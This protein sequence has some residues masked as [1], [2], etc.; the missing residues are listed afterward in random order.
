MRVHASGF[1]CYFT[2]VIPVPQAFRLSEDMKKALISL[3][4]EMK[5]AGIRG[6]YTPREN[7]HLMLAFIGEYNDPKKV[8]DVLDGL[9]FRPIPLSLDGVGSFGEVWWAGLKTSD[10]LSSLAARLRKALADAGIPFDSKRFS[11]HIT[12]LRRP[13]ALRMPPLAPQSASMTASRVRLMRSDRGK[14]GMIYTELY[15]VEAEN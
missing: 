11:P 14:N 5:R 2:I 9:R 6:N 10:A 8:S 7:M 12:L 15:G 13:D 3:Q 1:A 4:N